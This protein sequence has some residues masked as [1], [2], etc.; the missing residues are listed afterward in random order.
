MNR[1]HEACRRQERSQQGD[2]EKAKVLH[3][4]ALECEKGYFCEAHHNLGL[5]YRAEENYNKAYEHFLKAIEID[6]DY[7][8]AVEVL[9]DVEK[10]IQ[11]KE[12]LK[13]LF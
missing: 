1:N 3:Q 10:A 2:Y 8:V 13:E 12:Y 5:I 7:K 6:P 11:L 4:S 9:E